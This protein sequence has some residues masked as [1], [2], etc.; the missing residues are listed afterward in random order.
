MHLSLIHE[1][2]FLIDSF[3][4]MHRTTGRLEVMP[5]PRQL[6]GLDVLV[7]GP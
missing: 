1:A 3:P 2:M 5:L 4:Q 7:T 6:D